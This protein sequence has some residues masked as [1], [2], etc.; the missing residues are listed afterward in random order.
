MIQTVLGPIEPE[1]LGTTLMHEHV[2]IDLTSVFTPVTE[3]S[4]TGYVD[5]PVDMPMLRL[6]RRWP[7][8][9]CRDN[10]IL[11]DEDLAVAELRLF[12]QEGGATLVDTTARGVG[13]DPSA[14]RRISRATGVT[15]VQG[16][17]IYVEAAHPPWVASQSVEQLAEL[18]I[19]DVRDGIGDTGVCAGLIGEIGTSGVDP[20]T[21]Q[22]TGDITAAEEKVVRAAALASVETGA[23]VCVHLDPRGQGA[24]PVDQH[25]GSRGCTVGQNNSCPSRFAP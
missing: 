6:L 8:S 12:E 7:F 17:G 21:R 23:A 13:P 5:Q 18:L 10:V 11:N 19:S 24:I 25:S 3:T 22:K 20:V 1:T 14:M 4:L 16:T 9:L 2:L 15:I